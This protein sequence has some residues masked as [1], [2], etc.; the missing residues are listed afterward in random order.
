MG[1][2]HS[3]NSIVGYNVCNDN[4]AVYVQA[5]VCDQ[6]VCDLNICEVYEV[7]RL[8][9]KDPECTGMI[10]RMPLGKLNQKYTIEGHSKHGPSLAQSPLYKQS[11]KI[12]HQNIRSL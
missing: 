9:D 1:N 11:I 3:K 10:Q 4:G 2:L 6:Y 8:I 5:G 12:F 7:N